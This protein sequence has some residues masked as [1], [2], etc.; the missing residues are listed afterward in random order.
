VAPEIL[1]QSAKGYDA[2]VDY[3]SLGCILFECLSGYPPFTASS[4]DDIW[5]NVYHWKKVLER[6]AY[7]GQDEEFNLPD[8]GWDLITRL[9]S[10]PNV[11][12]KTMEH[13]S[14]HPFLKNLDLRTLREPGI[15]RPPLI[16]ALKSE[17]VRTM[18]TKG[19]LLL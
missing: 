6:P 4:N 15:T 14:K 5:V 17:F 12:Y 19:H 1:T 13:V 10:E 7:D 2:G 16:P 3:W 9:I 18:L 11:R 8:A